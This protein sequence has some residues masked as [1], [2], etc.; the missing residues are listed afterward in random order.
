MEFFIDK[1][2]FHRKGSYISSSSI[3]STIDAIVFTF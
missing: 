1:P 2:G 3:E